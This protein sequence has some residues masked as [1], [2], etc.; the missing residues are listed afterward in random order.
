MP[1]VG[2]EDADQQ[3]QPVVRVVVVQ[4]VR[5]Q[6]W[7]AASFMAV[8]GK[9]RMTPRDFKLDL[10]RSRAGGATRTAWGRRWAATCLGLAAVSAAAEPAM[11]MPEFRH[12]EPLPSVRQ[13]AA[14][15]GIPLEG[16]AEPAGAPGL[17][18]GDEAT[19]L[20][21]RIEGA[22]LEQWVISVRAVEPAGPVEA[23]PVRTAT[24]YASSGDHFTFSSGTA[25]LSLRMIGPLVAG[26]AGRPRATRPA[27]E[28]RRV[29]VS[30]DYLSLGLY[31]V[32]ALTLRLKAQLAAD[33]TIPPF[34]LNFGDRPFPPD[35]VATTRRQP[36]L[37]LITVDDQRAFNGALLALQEF[38]QTISRTP[39]LKDVLMSVVDV[40]WWAVVKA[41]GK[42][43][44]DINALNAVRTLPA[45]R[46]G[47]TD[48]RVVYAWPFELK[49]A[50]KQALRFQ[51]AVVPPRPPLAVTAGIVGIAAAPPGD[52][53][54]RLALELVAS[55]RGPRK[56]DLA[57]GG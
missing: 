3:P 45:A 54:P 6:K 33:P 15:A 1:A 28:E 46:A 36:G 20:V 39:G 53:G 52:T 57:G 40:P 18:P 47:L 7:V 23:T 49:I 35:Q 17:A 21:S 10:R 34:S 13:A 4:R 48:E 5:V 27:V 43:R 31:R 16:C 26:D 12:L 30:A 9:R 8:I 29:G 55:R 2:G 56:K 32:P 14:A 41:G 24:V 42:P 44:F 38:L 37:K 11:R 50:G 25:A 22:K 19:V 51:L